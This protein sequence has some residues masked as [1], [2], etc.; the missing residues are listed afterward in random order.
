MSELLSPG[1][2]VEEVPSQ[3]QVIQAVSTSNM[4][5]VG[6]TKRG[7][8]DTATLVTSLDQYFKTF[9]EFTRESFLPLTVAAFFSN[10]GRR[11]FVVRV[12]PGDAVAADALVQS[13]TTNQQIEIGDGTAVAFTKTAG[14]STLKDNAGASPLVVSSVS[15]RWRGAGT[16]VTVQDLRNRGNT[17]ALA[18]VLSQTSYEG[19]INPAS[20]VGG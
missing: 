20:L 14:T 4:G 2:F 10:G 6:F 7:P 13:Q 1:V 17:V 8:T 3:L 12:V 16:P 9:G 5:T 19:R 18:Q 11:A 15:F